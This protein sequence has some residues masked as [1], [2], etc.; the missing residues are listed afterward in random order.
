MSRTFEDLAVVQSEIGRHRC[1]F[2]YNILNDV[3]R[4]TIATPGHGSISAFAE[5]P[6]RYSRA[7]VAAYQ[8]YVSIEESRPRTVSHGGMRWPKGT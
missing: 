7:L 5:A 6:Y 8:V 1:L 3:G 4:R 2:S